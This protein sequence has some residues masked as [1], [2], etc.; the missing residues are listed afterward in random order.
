M[1]HLINV[2]DVT[3]MYPPRHSGS[4]FDHRPGLPKSAAS[5]GRSLIVLLVPPTIN[6]L[7]VSGREGWAPTAKNLCQN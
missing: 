7:V 5:K 2:A 6:V 3:D 4:G 1:G